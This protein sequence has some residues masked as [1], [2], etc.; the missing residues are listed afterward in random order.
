M[1][2]DF[3]APGEPDG[4]APGSQ[5]D[6][7]SDAGPVVWDQ[8][9]MMDRLMED[10]ELVHAVLQEFMLDLPS[11]VERLQRRVREEDPYQVGRQAHAIK[12]MAANAGAEA[13]RAVAYDLEQAGDAG[14]MELIRRRIAA[15][16]ALCEEIQSV[17]RQHLGEA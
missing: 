2:A 12:G 14:D 11:Q 7:S 15:L 6:E 17:L 1:N 10:E 8:A 13:V 4:R 5:H 3:S 16:P 9:G